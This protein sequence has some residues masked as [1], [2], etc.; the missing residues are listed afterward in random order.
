MRYSFPGIDKAIAELGYPQRV[1]FRGHVTV[2]QLL[3]TLF[4][5]PGGPE[6]EQRVFARLRQEAH[7]VPGVLP[8]AGVSALLATHYRYVPTRLL[9][10]TEQ[11]AVALFCA[12]VRESDQPAVFVLDPIAL[13][14]VS[15]VSGVITSTSD[16]WDA[17]RLSMWPLATSLPDFPIAIDLRSDYHDAR[18]ADT[19]YTMHGTNR[20]PLEQQCP[21]C[22]R[23]V[24]LT[25]EERSRSVAAILDGV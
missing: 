12:L 24:V 11:L 25:D 14:A 20:A 18:E 2:H 3:P 19:V 17:Q 9:A 5:F 1:W 23:R 22:V 15:D 4:R 13:N 10:W 21:Q 16:M 7:A 6:N 8:A